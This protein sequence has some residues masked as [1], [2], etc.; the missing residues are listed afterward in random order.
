MKAK[1]FTMLMT[2]MSFI[3][4]LPVQSF[5]QTPDT[6]DVPYIIDQEMRGAINKFILGDTTA[7][8]ERKNINRVYKLGRGLIYF[9]DSIME[10]DFP[11]T[12]I[13]DNEDPDNP[14][15]PPLL[16][17]GILDD[18]SAPNGLIWPYKNAT[19][20]NLYITGIRPDENKVNWSI[21]IQLHGDNCK[22]VFENCVFE[23][24]SFSSIRQFSSFA[25]IFIRD[26][27]FR[28]SMHPTSF[29]GGSAF[30]SQAGVPTDTV[31]M[32]NNT[33][34]NSGSYFFCPNRE[35]I[36]YS[37][38]EH[39]TIFT[40][41]GPVFYA[42]WVHNSYYKNNILFGIHAMGQYEL[43]IT[44]NDWDGEL[45]AIVSIDTIPTDIATREG[46]NE[47]DRIVRYENNAYFWPQQM[48]DFWAT[49]DTLEPALW[50]N[51]RTQ[52]M[53]DDKI[54]YPGFVVQGN[55]NI[56]P[57]FNADVM[58]QVDSVMKYCRLNRSGR[59]T[60]YGHY[61]YAKDQYPL[62][63]NALPF[64]PLQENL[65]YT[66]AALLT[67]GTDGLPLGDLNWF[68]DKKEEWISKVETK[69]EMM[70]SDFELSQNYPN[71]FNPITTIKFKMN[72]SAQIK[73][74]V[75][76]T[77]GQR[78]KTLVDEKM[79]AGNHTTIWNAQDDKGNMMASGVYYY[80]LE[81]ESFKIA[82]KMVLL[83]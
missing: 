77:L 15:P 44:W 23:G 2:G 46:I 29:L 12:L 52:A 17:R 4:T 64:W 74:I 71:P 75:Y 21:A 8:G 69:F 45:S 81:S 32:T 47:A 61:Y 48:V 70:P 79:M 83:K 19:F 55:M 35:Y 5:A 78:V 42:P 73:L 66:N 3:I 57:G 38:V 1:F 43:E 49:T 10:V 67:A 16:A 53:L 33:F 22:Y 65:A 51:D 40:N 80:R 76:N 39:N 72:K 24:W 59:N 13:A 37:L 25:K 58:A 26:C 63:F 18:N 34:F 7:N 82:R 54:N 27:H 60:N 11:L 36:S 20:K 41:H 30:V 9:F 28:N 62:L 31:V 14:T 68:P 50:I 56:D 6:V